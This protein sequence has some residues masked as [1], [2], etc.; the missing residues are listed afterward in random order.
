MGLR[1][2]YP[3]T[4][5]KITVSRRCYVFYF[6]AHIDGRGLGRRTADDAHSRAQRNARVRAPCPYVA[7]VTCR[8]DST[9][10]PHSVHAV[11]FMCINKNKLPFG[12][13]S[14]TCRKAD[15]RYGDPISLPSLYPVPVGARSQVEPLGMTSLGR[16]TYDV[17]ARWPRTGEP[18][19]YPPQGMQ[20]TRRPRSGARRWLSLPPRACMHAVYTGL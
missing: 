6:I 18:A 13:R 11:L 15:H 10:A 14:V 1:T 17:P 20:S 4:R 12:Y 5:K 2:P 16:R 7:R 3:Y 9:T 19:G 8:S